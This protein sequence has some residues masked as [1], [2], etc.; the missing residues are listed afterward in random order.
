MALAFAFHPTSLDMAVPRN[1]ELSTIYIRW[2]Q[3]SKGVLFLR[4][5][6]IISLVLEA[7]RLRSLLLRHHTRLPTSSRYEDSS[8]SL[9]RPSTVLS[10][11]SLTNPN[12]RVVANLITLVK[13][14]YDLRSH[15]WRRNRAEARG[16]SPVGCPYFAQWCPT[17]RLLGPWKVLGGS[18][19]SSNAQKV[20]RT[21]IE[22]CGTI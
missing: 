1:L 19:E 21:D 3:G 4:K 8:A 11:A 17:S 12:G 18:L 13:S 16:S 14:W 22:A 9:T 15:L 20:P 6:I 5:P 7:S 2:I 10:S